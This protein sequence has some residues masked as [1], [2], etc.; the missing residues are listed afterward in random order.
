[1][2]TKDLYEQ[3]YL[4]WLEETA[5][6]LRQRQT[7]VLDWEHLGEEIEALGNEQRHKADSY[8]LQLLIHLLLYQYWPEELERCAKGWQ[9]EI[10]NFRV[11]LELLLE[12]KTLYNYFLTRIAVIYPKAVKRVRQKSQLAAAIFAESCPYSPEQILDSDFL[13]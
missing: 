1:M 7:D 6:Q 13:P 12:S 10:G 8:L 4:A 9:D 11:E 3:D 2:T 5:K